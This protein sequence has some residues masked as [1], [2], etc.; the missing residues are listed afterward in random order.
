[1]HITAEKLKSILVGSG[2]VDEKSFNDAG[3][4]SARLGQTIPNVLIG[5]GSIT[6]KYL[7]E[8]LGPY[9]NVPQMNLEQVTI[10]LQTLELIP[11]VYAKARGVV[12]FEEDKER[13]VLKVAMT[14]PLDYETIEF[15]RAKLGQWVE[16]Y[17]TST[18]S[19]K[20]GL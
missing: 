1:M 20:Y 9:V 19:L 4:E 2:I 14:D 15:L 6:E 18:S 11:E 17:F 16:Q 3:D 10:P 13:K 5:R 8:L 7:V 12:A